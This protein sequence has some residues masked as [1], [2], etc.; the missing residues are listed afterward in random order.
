MKGI[1]SPKPTLPQEFK[2]HTGTRAEIHNMSKS[3]NHSNEGSGFKFIA[4]KMPNF[5]KIKEVPKPSPKKI[6]VPVG[7]H[8]SSTVRAEERKLFD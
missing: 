2:F 7:I 1:A 8:L 4:N 5:S 6:T 3:P